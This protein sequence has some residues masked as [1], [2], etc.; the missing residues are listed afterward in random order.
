MVDVGVE[1]GGRTCSSGE[2]FQRNDLMVSMVG[3]CAP[4]GRVEAV[5]LG[6]ARESV[7]RKKWVGRMVVLSMGLFGSVNRPGQSDVCCQDLEQGGAF[8]TTAKL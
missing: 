5:G 3:L 7:G 1:A 8:T 4:A 6:Q 2:G